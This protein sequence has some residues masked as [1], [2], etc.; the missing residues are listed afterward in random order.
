MTKR[1]FSNLILILLISIFLSGCS[2]LDGLLFTKDTVPEYSFSGYVY[3]DGSPLSGATV[4][5]GL[6]LTTTNDEGYYSFSGLKQAVEVSVKKDGYLFE[7]DAKTV[8]GISSNINFEGYELFEKSGVVKNGDVVVSNVSIRA[9]SKGGVYTTQSDSAGRFYLENLAGTVKV[10]ANKDRFNFFTQSFSISKEDDIVVSGIANVGGRITADITPQASDF[11]LKLNGNNVQINDDLTFDLGSVSM[12]DEVTIESET[13]YIAS[14][15]ILVSSEDDIVFA[16]KKLY[17]LEGTVA[18]GSVLLS[19]VEVSVNGRHTTSQNGSFKIEGFYG[20]GDVKFELDGYKFDDARVSYENREL[21]VKGLTSVSVALS[22]DSGNDYK[23]ISVKVGD[24]VFANCTRQGVFALNDISL[25]DTVEIVASDFASVTPFKILDRTTKNVELKRLYDVSVVCNCDG[26]ALEDVCVKVDGEEYGTLGADGIQ[27]PRLYGSHIVSLEKDGYV[28]LT[29]YNVNAFSKD[30]VATAF[31]LFDITGNVHSGDIVLNG[32]KVTYRGNEYLCDSLGNYTVV[33]AYGVSDLSVVCDGYNGVDTS[34]DIKNATT[35]FNLTYDITGTIEC[36]RA[37]VFGVKVEANNTATYSD[38]NGKFEFLGL[39]GTT[40]ITFE[41][42]HYSIGSVSVSNAQEISVSSTYEIVGNVNTSE[43]VI[44]GLEIILVGEDIKTTT[45]DKSGNY[46]FEGLSGNYTIYYSDKT[47]FDL[48]PKQ[49]TIKEG[50]NYNFSNKGFNFG[51]VVKCGESPL[52][53]VTVAI[54]SSKVTTDVN[55]QY[56]FPLVTQSGVITL[57]KEGYTFEGS[58]TTITEDFADRRDVDF[59]ATYKVVILVSSGKTLLDQVKVSLDGEEKGVTENGTLEI[60]GLSGEHSLSLALNKYKFVGTTQVSGYKALSFQAFFDVDVTLK[61]GDAKVSGAGYSINGKARNGTSNANGELTITDLKL[62]DQLTFEKENYTF[63]G[64]NIVEYVETLSVNSTYKVSGTI[65]NCGSPLE[66][67]RISVVGSD[68]MTTLSNAQGRFEFEGV[69]GAITLHFEK[70]GFEFENVQVSSADE[71][72]ARCKYSVSGTVKLASGTGISG[73]KIYDGTTLLTTTANN[74]SF[75]IEGLSSV[76]MLTFEKYGYTFEG[77]YEVG[78]PTSGMSVY[79]TYEISGRVTSGSVA[80]Q[81]AKVSVGTNFEAK[82]DANGYYKIS[83]LDR[84][85]EVDLTAS[86]YD[87]ALP[88]MVKGYSGSANFELTYS[89]VI[90]VN[91]EY[92]DISVAISGETN[93]TNKYSINTITLSSL[94]GIN[95]ITIS[96]SSYRINPKDTFGVKISE[97][98]EITTQLVYTIKGTV[99]TDEGVVVPYANI[100]VG[101]TTAKAN[102]NGVYEV[103][104]LVGANKLS[105]TLPF[106]GYSSTA[107]IQKDYGQVSNAGTYD[108]VFS[109]KAFWLGLLNHSYNNLRNG[110]GYQIVGTGTVVAIAEMITI[111]SYSKVDVH[112]KQDKNGIK[113]FENK[114]NGEE[115]A[116]VD[117]NVSLLTVYNTKTGEVKS[118]FVAGEDEVKET[119]V[120]YPA[121]WNAWNNGSTVGGVEAY[122]NKY[123]V[124]IDGFSP[125]IIN[126]NTINSATKVSDSGNDYV[127]KLDMNTT[128]SVANY[129]ILM[130]VMCNKKDM[131]GF[132]SITLTVTISK[133]GYIKEMKMYEKYAVRT[134]K[135][136]GSTLYEDKK[137][138]VTGD[139]TYTFYTNENNTIN[140]IDISTPL[141]AVANIR[142][143][144]N[145]DDVSTLKS[146]K[147]A[148]TPKFDLIVCK[149][150]EIL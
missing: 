17:D 103:T 141:T 22:L 99:K 67:V 66:G 8:S 63:E 138:N 61:T 20:E 51:G 108:I 150:E 143:L 6:N 96:K 47:S 91:G 1:R 16:S 129:N 5:C 12:G 127:F 126:L 44:E 41:K 92:K 48:K 125:Y 26:V 57:S 84:E 14:N 131:E 29:T 31:E 113:V 114:N 64:K 73:V 36:G 70:S 52:E 35:N 115:K 139:I 120:N 119:T 72:L 23:N 18:C 140:D 132:S 46:S 93:R 133:T 74:G 121:T 81:N 60:L 98:I 10:T 83:G 75:V 101:E 21:D 28:F 105:A 128:T 97:T 104:G 37:K 95:T 4:D 90:R 39:I 58:G 111:E 25:G 145:Y 142:T 116:N 80:V 112:Y 135:N 130:G 147:K 87:K 56:L 117:P 85:V 3:A 49:Y 78:E 77:D 124:D 30:I 79:G 89:V 76:V 109:A 148:S 40:Q 19:G 65:S 34:V 118:Q 100:I 50:G 43:G 59:D 45:T 69:Q 82:T 24:K 9:E 123:G 68:E 11:T 86:G 107:D 33:G 32:A 62:G 94:K 7:G 54:G 106:A 146:I 55:G 2:L 15:R 137:A 134:N 122:K 149:K 144:E 42:E 53:G 110:N 88:I 13:Y 38:T 136:V 102:E 27:I 71:V